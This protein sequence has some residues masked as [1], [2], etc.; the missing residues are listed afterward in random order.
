[1]ARLKELIM[2]ELKRRSI[3]RGFKTLGL[4]LARNGEDPGFLDSLAFCF[5]TYPNRRTVGPSV[6]IISTQLVQLFQAISK[7]TVKYPFSVCNFNIGNIKPNRKYEVWEFQ[8]GMDFTPIF[9][10]IF[11]NIEEYAYPF[12]RE[13]SNIPSLIE[14]LEDPCSGI[15]SE[16]RFFNLPLLYLMA[17]NKDAGIKY[18]EKELPRYGNLVDDYKNYYHNY[19]AFDESS[20]VLKKE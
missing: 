12:W 2:P 14:I 10:D 20:F 13:M 6:G 7:T 4:Y 16:T 9:D 3:D 11:K 1:M 15:V 19:C 17:G 5:C 18:L 8:E